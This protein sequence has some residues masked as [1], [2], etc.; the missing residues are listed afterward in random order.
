MIQ[1]GAALTGISGL[2]GQSVARASTKARMLRIGLITPPPHQWN[3]T[4]EAVAEDLSDATDGRLSISLFPSG[5]LGSESQMLQLLQL[6][7]I[8]L[9]FLTTS[10]FANRLSGFG[11][12]Y[13]PYIVKT[14]TQ[15]ARLLAGE[16]SARILSE[17]SRIGLH[18][19]G[20]GMAG[21]R[22]VVSR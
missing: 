18:G 10:E 19:L 17:V 22:Q 12:F 9:A 1:G 3:R 13:T 11:A 20:F 14:A 8:D 21:M 16:V 4:A 15:S 6:G 2:A 7:A 5:Q